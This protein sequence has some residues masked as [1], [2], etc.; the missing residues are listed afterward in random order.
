MNLIYLSILLY[1]LIPIIIGRAFLLL[2]NKITSRKK[3]IDHPS[4]LEQ[5]LTISEHFT[6]GLFSIFILA[7]SIKYLINPLIDQ[8]FRNIFSISLITLILISLTINLFNFPKLR[9]LFT[10][11]NLSLFITMIILSFFS[12]SLI[13]YRSP[14]PLNWDLYEHQTLVNNLLRGKY[15]FFTSEISDTFGFP[16]YPTMFHTLLAISQVFFDLNPSNILT[17]W[18]YMGLITMF[19]SCI[20][21]YCFAFVIT[22]K[23]NI[24]L[25]SLILNCLIFDSVGA[26]TNLMFLPQSQTALLFILLYSLALHRIQNHKIPGLIVIPT[27][28]ILIFSHYIIGTFAAFLYLSTWLYFRFNKYINE[29]SYHLPIIEIF[30]VIAFSSVIISYYLDLSFINRGEA[31]EYIYSLTEKINYTQRIYAFSLFVFLPIGLLFAFKQKKRIY[32]QL[33]ALLT[34]GFLAIFLSKFPYIFKFYTIGRFFIHLIVVF[35]LWTLIKKISNSLLKS[36]A[37]AL[38]FIFFVFVL[39]LNLQTWKGWLNNKGNYVHLSEDDLNASFYLKEHYDPQTTI[40]FS[41]PTTQYYLEALSGINSPGGFAMSYQNRDLFHDIYIIQ[42]NQQK[43]KTLHSIKDKLETSTKF[44][45]IISGRTRLWNQMEKEKRN[46]FTYQIWEPHH[47]AFVD[48]LY[49][50]SLQD[51]K[52]FLLIYQNPSIAILEIK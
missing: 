28:I 44:L 5:I 30:F 16:S 7:L 29:I 6:I 36:V 27:L 11:R 9:H 8:P 49:I 10:W 12:F 26:F 20:A 52:H 3:N 40:L 17:Y 23:R 2:S 43:N 19:I 14:Y 47:L 18:H 42:N 1:Y 24:A 31:V 48:L 4:T 22:K 13:T 39:I 15:S 34:L 37:I 51:D 25:L 46:S 33:T 21:A 41:D 45:Y 50:Q 32:Y 38:T 35:G